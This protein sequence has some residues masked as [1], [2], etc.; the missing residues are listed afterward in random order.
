MNLPVYATVTVYTRQVTFHKVP[1]NT[2]MFNR[3]QEK[4]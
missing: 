2:A 4:R 3:A 1:E